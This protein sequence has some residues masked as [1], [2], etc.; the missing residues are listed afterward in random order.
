MKNK[1]LLSLFIA[2]LSAHSIFSMS[3]K[4]QQEQLRHIINLKVITVKQNRFETAD[5][6]GSI[7]LE[8]DPRGLISLENTRMLYAALHLVYKSLPEKMH[9]TIIP[10]L[11][12]EIQIETARYNLLQQK[13]T[14]FTS[15]EKI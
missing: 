9:N 7:S 8:T 14:I 15:H 6:D 1:L 4:L 13:R 10:Q 12:E 11:D 2:S 3:S 5:P